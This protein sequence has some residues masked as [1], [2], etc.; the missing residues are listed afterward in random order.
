M[1]AG[2]RDPALA[3]DPNLVCHDAAEV[4]LLLEQCNTA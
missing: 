4:H 3:D 1:L 2:A